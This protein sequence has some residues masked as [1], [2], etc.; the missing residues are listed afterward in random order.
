MK[1]N[2]FVLL[3]ILGS[4]FSCKEKHYLE[5]KGFGEITEIR[6]QHFGEGLYHVFVKCKYLKGNDTIEGVFEYKYETIYSSRFNKGQRVRVF[7]NE[8][9]DRD[10]ILKGIYTPAP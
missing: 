9:N 7:Y 1:Y 6:K 10:L 5:S 2:L 4:F 8:L 3:F